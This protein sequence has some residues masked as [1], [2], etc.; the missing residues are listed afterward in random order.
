MLKVKN[1]LY[2]CGGG[3]HVFVVDG[4]SSRDGSRD[5]YSN[6]SDWYSARSIGCLVF[7]CFFSATLCFTHSTH[8]ELET[9]LRG[10][11]EWGTVGD[12]AEG[13]Q[14][15]GWDKAECIRDL[16][17]IKCTELLHIWKGGG[18]WGKEANGGAKG[19]VGRRLQEGRGKGGNSDQRHVK[20]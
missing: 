8:T 19:V 10:L 1:S 5:R 4:F 15:W 11:W 13:V 14:T 3:N 16:T 9:G 6:K 7:Y 20:R 12:A 2:V 17:G 18:D